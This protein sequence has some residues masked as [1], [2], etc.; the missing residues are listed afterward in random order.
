M[1]DHGSYRKKQLIVFSAIG[2]IA[3]MLIGAVPFVWMAGVL[4]VIANVSFGAGVVCF[5]AYL[6]LLVRNID[7]IR[8]KREQITRLE[9]EI[10]S[11]SG[12]P[13]QPGTLSANVSDI[14]GATDLANGADN[15]QRVLGSNSQQTGTDLSDIEHSSQH[16]DEMTDKLNEEKGHLMGDISAKGFAS[17]YFGGIVLLLVCLYIS[18]RDKSSIWSL[19]FGIFLSGLWWFIF[20]ALA[21]IWLKPRPGPELRLEDSGKSH[22][23]LWVAS[24]ISN[25]ALLFAKTSLQLPQNQLILLSLEVPICALV[26]TL[27]FPKVQQALGYN[28]KQMVLLLL[29]L[30]VMIPVY[31]TLGLVLSF[32]PHLSSA[33]ELFA[34]AAYFGFLI[35][36]IQ[37]FCRSLFAGL[38]PRGRESEFFGLYAITDKGS[39]W[40]GPLVIAAI[41]DRTHEIRHAFVFLLVLLSLPIPIIYFGVDLDQGRLDAENVS[42]ELQQAQASEE[43]Y[44]HEPSGESDRLLSFGIL[45]FSR[46]LNI[47][48]LDQVVHTM[49][50]STGPEHKLAQQVLTQ[51]QEN[52]E[53]W[54]RVDAILDNSK[55]PQT[56]YIALQILEKLVQTRWKLLPP[57]Q[58]QGIRNYAVGLIVKLSSDEA[59]L[60]RERMLLNKLNL[61]L[62]QILKQEWPHAWP[63]FIPEI[64]VSSKSNLS[65][66]E[67]NMVILKLL[68]EEIF[69][70]SAEQM[71]QTKT[72]NLKNSMCG[73]FSEI[74]Q[75]CSEVLEKANKPSLIKA[76]L[77]TLL[78][79]LNWI[80][81]GYIFETNI[82]E[83]LR[84]R[85]LD[86]PQFRNI[87][88]ACLREIGS[89]SVA[90]DYNDKFVILFNM[91][92]TSIA[93]TIPI[94][95]NIAEMYEDAGDDEQKY[96]ANVAMFITGFL[97]VH[98]KLVENPQNR[99]VLLV[100]HQYLLKISQVEDREIFK[101]CL[102]YWSKLVAELYEE[103]QQLP[104]M[105]LPQ[106]SLGTG[107]MQSSGSV[108]LR[109][110][111]YT[112]VLSRLRVIMIER[113]VKPEEVLIVENEE[114]EIVREVMKES[115]TI[116]LYKSM[117]EVLVYLT[118][119]DCLDT[120]RIMSE[121]LTKQVDNSE[122]SWSNLNKLCWAIGSIS[123]AMNEEAEKRF[124]VT[125][126]KELLGLCEMKRGKDNKAVVASNIMYI[127]G[128]YPRFL[129]AHWKFLK[130][131]V[132]KLFEFMH[133]THDGV[134]DMACD[135]FIK[136]SQKCRRHF[137][138]QQSQEVMPFIDEILGT[139]DKITSDLS[140]AQIHTFYEAIGYMVSAQPNRL[141]QERLI[142]KAMQTP[143]QYWDSI[144]Q[145]ANLNVKN[146][147]NPENLKVLASVLKTNV[148]ACGSIGP[149]FF[150]QLGHIYLDLLA[151]YKAVSQLI[152]E[153]V[154]SMGPVALRTPR[155]R[156]MRT[157][158]KEILHLIETYV[159]KADDL[160]EVTQKIIP[161]VLEAV[162]GDYQ[163][164]VE[165][166]R[167][168]E[169][170]SVM[171]TIVT[172][173]GSLLN[174]KIPII[175]ESVFDV[176][177]NMINKD[178]AEYPDHRVGFFKLVRAIN[179]HCFPALMKL[180]P[181]QLR[182]IMDSVVWAFKHTMRDI[183]DT[184]LNI[185]LEVINNFSDSDVTT[186]NQFYQAYF[187]NILNDI[188]YVLTDNNHKS[189]FKLQSQ[190]LARM[191]L[192]VESGAVH[193]P[194][195]SPAQVTDPN[196]TNS[197][198]L[199]EYM[200]N[201]LQNAFPH[202]QPSQI[203]T[204]TI[205]LFE[206]NRDSNK[207]KLHLR[208]FL[209]QLT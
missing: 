173:L 115:D 122:W 53:S 177:L 76:T 180:P 37:S 70:F 22:G 87:T 159:N 208:D 205:A 200:M 78:R 29:V 103:I 143:N 117:R 85:F 139:L 111:F 84:S 15:V 95:G 136:I 112:E 109:K 75:L 13:V 63:G 152:S 14:A 170:L 41:T 62:V 188:F 118:H 19:K 185:C 5:N 98:L 44:D 93:K 97:N 149:G 69:D 55:D 25:V 183:A 10:E 72:K 27:A 204:F 64:V 186:A 138:L 100:A 154:A 155:V 125:V 77:E 18:Y 160:T 79:F 71:T 130:T 132:N 113:M 67:N 86:V 51:F 150:S 7:H 30:L 174:D 123:G 192:L 26:G 144:M 8:S 57:E 203:R 197:Q 156:Q 108:S 157:V 168:A 164:N 206:T 73:E 171:S 17:G 82:V 49:Y 38:V 198:F 88:L 58:C 28:Q 56:K 3:T 83:N 32:W 201:L 46:D 199:R 133:E 191:F 42:L 172:K 145:Q 167:D 126:I 65:L 35:G 91:V 31:G 66:C 169:V 54:R 11:Q 162:L 114:G 163:R 207:F 50:Y 151:V 127:V 193:A 9:E 68:S 74:F 148:A 60:L 80:P 194:L 102:E 36:A 1:A 161:G 119:L 90:A 196:M 106:L 23:S 175:L 110:N 39:S 202:L 101:I 4:S 131:V 107:I 2:A 140:P 105:E 128:Q 181:T 59:T 209:I 96:I 166:A 116:T 184:G 153:T 89:L 24:R 20:A 47:D 190:V 43:R 121:K 34:V 189:G 92:M 99:E 187:L 135:T 147:D 81:L 16:L 40:L 52:P 120:E 33:K 21:G 104:V 141:A 142:A 45:D 178:F 6:P 195:F 48:L 176:T 129:K 94:G 12:H 165:P 137:V 61:V 158:K 134:Q 179:Y 124:L 146:L 182:L